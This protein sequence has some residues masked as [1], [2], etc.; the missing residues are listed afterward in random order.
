MESLITENAGGKQNHGIFQPVVLGLNA[1]REESAAFQRETPGA[2][3]RF[4][5]FQ[6]NRLLFK[7][8]CLNVV[9]SQAVLMKG[10]LGLRRIKTSLKRSWPCCAVSG[11]MVRRRRD[12]W[13]TSFTPTAKAR[14][15]R[16]FTSC[17]NGWKRRELSSATRAVRAKCFLP[18]SIATI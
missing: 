12:N 2:Y 13:P 5:K 6:E 4:Q 1:A 11:R 18:S 10:P 7:T 16:P 3:A 17:W 8:I 14:T 9:G 15:Q